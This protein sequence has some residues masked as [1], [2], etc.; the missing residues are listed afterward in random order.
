MCTNRQQDAGCL[1]DVDRCEQP[2]DRHVRESTF[3]QYGCNVF[4]V[5]AKDDKQE[6]D[7]EKQE[8]DGPVGEGFSDTF[9]QNAHIVPGGGFGPR[10]IPDQDNKGDGCKNRHGGTDQEHCIP[11]PDDQEAACQFAADDPGL[12]T[13]LIRPLWAV[14][15]LD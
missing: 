1:G 9:F 5:D 2:C 3:G 4:V 13:A 10:N 8:S 15:R 7:R 6:C 12:G 11:T 14:K